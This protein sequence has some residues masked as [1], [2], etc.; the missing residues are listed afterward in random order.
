MDIR[1]KRPAICCSSSSA[2]RSRRSRRLDFFSALPR[3]VDSGDCSCVCEF[4]GA[5]FWYLERVAMFSTPAHPR[6]SHCCQDGG[7]VLPYPPAFD[8]DF[9]ALYEN[10][11]FM[12]DIRA[13]NSMFSMTSFVL[14]FYL[15]LSPLLFCLVENRRVP[16]LPIVCNS[17]DQW[18]HRRRPGSFSY[19]SHLTTSKNKEAPTFPIDLQPS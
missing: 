6:Y 13:Y 5:Y 2:P 19:P 18:R 1:A 3:Y 4:C 8:P 7:V 10:V 11:S 9:V 14:P 17:V 16:A 15:T 12:K